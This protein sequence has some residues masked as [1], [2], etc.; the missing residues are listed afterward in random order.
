MACKVDGVEWTRPI[1]LTKR[2][3]LSIISGISDVFGFA[4]PL[5]IRTK[6]GIQELWKGGYE[7]DQ[8]L[9]QQVKDNWYKW[10]DE[11]S[12]L[13]DV[14]FQRCFT[15]ENVLGKPFLIIFS[16]ASEKAFGAVA[17]IRWRLMDGSFA[18]RL[19]M[20]KSRVA[21]V[22][23]LTMPKLELQA[24]VI[25]CTLNHTIRSECRLEFEKTIFFCDSMIGLAWIQNETRS[26]TVFVSVRIAEIKAK[27]DPADWRYCSTDLNVADDVTPGLCVDN[28]SGRWKHGEAFLLQPED[29]WPSM[30][31]SQDNDANDML[32]EC[33]KVNVVVNLP[34][35]CPLM[36]FTKRFS[37]Y[38]RAVRVLAVIRR[39][40]H[41]CKA[42]KVATYQRLSGALTVAELEEAE[43]VLVK[44]AQSA[45]KPLIQKN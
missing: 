8:D 44:D 18:V 29:Q 31:L 9:P 10:F 34:A 15:P 33:R 26:F 5:I 7:W 3:V 4:A 39:F 14:T 36:Q 1:K 2:M 25:A 22:K 6:I 23:E 16:D 35:C 40:I 21:P 11:L 19:I 45:I 42:R 24:A 38:R 12:K 41:N 37:K 27:S 13:K 30:Q 32:I 28:L 17:Y 20:A 43:K